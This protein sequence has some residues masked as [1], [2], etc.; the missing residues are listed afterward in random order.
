MGDHMCSSM[1]SCFVQFPEVSEPVSELQ[2]DRLLFFGSSETPGKSMGGLPSAKFE[3]T[4]GLL[5]FSSV[6][7][8]YKWSLF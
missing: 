3:V 2:A 8:N 7:I 4:F 1:I 5:G 6:R